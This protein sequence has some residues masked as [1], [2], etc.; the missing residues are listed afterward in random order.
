RGVH[1]HHAALGCSGDVDI[2]ETD[3]GT[4]D[5]LQV[6]SRGENLGVDGGSRTDEQ[7]VRFRNSSEQRGAVRAVHPA[8][9]DTVT[10]RIDGRLRKLVGDQ[11]YW[12][13]ILAHVRTPCVVNVWAVDGA[14]T[15]HKGVFIRDRP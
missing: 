9:L 7:S 11:D 1:D 10:E 12:T 13:A 5:D 2:V 6:R 4:A 15:R 3:T 14:G 8:H